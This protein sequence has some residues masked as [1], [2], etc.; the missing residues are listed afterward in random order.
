MS[1]HTQLMWGITFIT[2]TTI[3]FGGLV[4]L[5]VV[6]GGF[7]GAAH[8]PALAIL[9]YAGAATLVGVTLAVGIGMVRAPQPR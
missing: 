4:L 1:R 3:V 6:S 5:G 2:V 7:F 8:F 9:L